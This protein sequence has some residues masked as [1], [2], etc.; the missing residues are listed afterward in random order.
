MSNEEEIRTGVASAPQGW[1]S[2]R[3]QVD[4]GLGGEG[5]EGFFLQVPQCRE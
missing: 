2:C 5:T 3:D 4:L 1:V